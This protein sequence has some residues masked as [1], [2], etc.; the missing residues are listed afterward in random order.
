MVIASLMFGCMYEKHLSIS[1]I[2]E[3]L[4]IKQQ[5]VIDTTRKI[6]LA[7]K[8]RMN[9]TIDSAIQIVTEETE[10]PLVPYIKSMSK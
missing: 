1:E 6:L 5:E 9:Q 7:Y 10:I 2:C 4:C 3:L 8:E